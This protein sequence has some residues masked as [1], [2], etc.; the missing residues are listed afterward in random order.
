MGTLY[1][2]KNNFCHEYSSIGYIYNT[3]Y[4]Y[5][6]SL[7][8]IQCK[9]NSSNEYELVDVTKTSC[10][11]LKNDGV[12]SDGEL[13]K[14]TETINDEEITSFNICIDT[15]VEPSISLKLED[16]Y[17]ISKENKIKEI[18]VMV[19]TNNGNIFGN[20][21]NKYVN[22]KVESKNIKFLKGNFNI[23]YLFFFFFSFFKK[24]LLNI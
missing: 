15:T 10:S 9:T 23:F 5:N 8:F 17:F 18:E 2:C 1:E 12:A 3:V 22:I 20:K 24:I 6:L 16:E 21:K 13:F 7:P 19:S 14:T 11:A 4:D